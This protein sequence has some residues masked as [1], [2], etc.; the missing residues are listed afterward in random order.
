MDEDK[1]DLY[2]AIVDRKSIGSD[3]APYSGSSSRALPEILVTN[4]FDPF[5]LGDQFDNVLDYRSAIDD[6]FADQASGVLGDNQ[7]ATAQSVGSSLDLSG[8]AIQASVRDS[9]FARIDEINA[10]PTLTKEQ[11]REAASEVLTILNIPHDPDTLDPFSR[12]DKDGFIGRELVVDTGADAGATAADAASAAATVIGSV[13]GG[14]SG[15]GSGSNASSGSAA[16][17]AS[18]NSGVDNPNEVFTYDKASDTFVDANGNAYPA[19]VTNN[20]TLVDGGQY[21]VT[22]VVGTDKVVAEHVVG[23]TNTDNT[24]AG[25]TNIILT[26]A[27]STNTVSDNNTAANTGTVL[28]GDDYGTATV[29]TTVTPPGGGVVVSLPPGGGVGPAGP[30]GGVGP[31]GPAGPAGA[32]GGVGPAGPAGAAGI[33]GA[34]GATGATGAKGDKGEKGDPGVTTLMTIA[35]NTPVTDKARAKLD[36]IR[37]DP[38]SLLSRLFG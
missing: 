27:G 37:L 28:S 33:A 20:A 9:A 21:T 30:A 11:K 1:D 7:L 6:F 17:N 13:A 2:G 8:D 3:D 18:A 32:A 12:T 24:N 35:D 19:G 22:P 4:K 26:P 38:T 25:N 5:A 16:S 29:D 14:K 36:R 15:G 10:D 31:A 23:Q 34:V